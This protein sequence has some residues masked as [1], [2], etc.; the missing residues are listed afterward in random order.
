MG[1]PACGL[2]APCSRCG[3]CPV[4]CRPLQATEGEVCST[5]AGEGCDCHHGAFLRGCSVEFYDGLLSAV[6]SGNDLVL[7]KV[8]LGL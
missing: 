8:T 6:N 1:L 4:S 7:N 3:R 2:D 5:L